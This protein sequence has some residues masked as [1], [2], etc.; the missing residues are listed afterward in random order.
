[1]RRFDPLSEPVARSMA[2]TDPLS[3]ESSVERAALH[4]QE[5][6]VGVV[7]IEDD[8]R[9]VGVWTEKSL[10]RALADGV[11]LDSAIAPF[12]DQSAP[13]IG[14]SESGAAALRLMVE[15]GV[16]H[17]VVL[18]PHRMV[19]G[20]VTASRLTVTTLEA[21]RPRQIG[22]MATPFGVFLT[23]GSVTGGAKPWMLMTSG[24]YLF[25]LFLTAA[26]LMLWL[27]RSV[28]AGN[29]LT[30]FYEAGTVVVFLLLLRLSPLAKIHAA[31]HKVVHAI[32]QREPLT[33]ES[34]R[35]MPRVHPRCGTNFAGAMT[36]FMSA[37]GLTFIAEMELRVLI[38]LIATVLLFRPFGTFLQLAGTTAPP[39]EKHLQLGIQ[40]ANDFLDKYERSPQLAGSVPKRLWNSGLF[41]IMGGAMA[42][43]LVVWL[44]YEALRVPEVWRVFSGIL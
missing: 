26:H 31:E 34:V 41:Q 37:L 5:E 28:P 16:P 23:N 2:L 3:S 32:E 1:M 43:Q 24:A 39:K 8:Q 18:D 42:A 7:P 14:S 29:W 21:A 30:Q 44:I 33:M 19:A 4:L 17:L 38:G 27:T 22:G 15:L 40:A 10:A 20:V 6:G 35:R 25:L 12:V 9:F 36:I 13:T 11:P